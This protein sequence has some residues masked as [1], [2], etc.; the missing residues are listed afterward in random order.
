MRTDLVESALAMA[1]TM[2]GHLPGQVIF[3][4]DRGTQGGFN[5]SSQHRVVNLSVVGLQALPP[6]FSMRVSYGGG[7]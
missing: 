3:H 5:P 4:A 2:R 7:C 6:E 1:L